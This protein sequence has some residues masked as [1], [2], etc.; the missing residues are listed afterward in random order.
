MMQRTVISR[1]I[2]LLKKYRITKAALFGSFARGTTKKKSDIDLLID[3]KDKKTFIDLAALQH[4]LE[5]ALGRD[6]DLVTF[7]SLNPRLA[8]YILRDSVSIL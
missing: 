8:P 4:E 6:V 5:D 1:I 2:P 7:R 3:F